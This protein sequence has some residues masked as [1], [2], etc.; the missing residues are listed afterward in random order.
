MVVANSHFTINAEKL[1]LASNV[2]LID[3]EGL[4]NIMYNK[5]RKKNRIA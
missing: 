1:A 5:K 2:T 3:R 4:M